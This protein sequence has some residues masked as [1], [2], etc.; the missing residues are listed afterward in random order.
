MSL[1]KVQKVKKIYGAHQN[2]VAAISEAA[3]EIK[4]NEFIALMGP[5]GSGKTTLLSILGGLNAP[6]DGSVVIDDIDIYNLKIER[7]AD[8]RREYLGFVF[9]EFQLVPYLTAIAPTNQITVFNL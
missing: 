6:T 3:L 9:Q 7:L 1:I 4:E 2:P 8:F 5:S